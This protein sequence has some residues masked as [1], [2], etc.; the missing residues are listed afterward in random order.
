MKTKR[1]LEEIWLEILDEETTQQILDQ[2]RFSGTGKHISEEQNAVA[3]ALLHETQR[4]IAG[5]SNP[6]EQLTI[7]REARAAWH[8]SL[9]P[10][11]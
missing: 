4:R 11:W 7:A 3:L 10:T 8:K 6:D 1:T 9:Q 2:F 5:T